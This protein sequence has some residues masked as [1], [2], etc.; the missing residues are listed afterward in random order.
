MSCCFN[1]IPQGEVME[2]FFRK[3][4]EE[5]KCEQLMEVSLTN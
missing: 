4:K 2:V 5:T 3:K 1:L